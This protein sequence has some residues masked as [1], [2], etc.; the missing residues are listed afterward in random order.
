ML[1][2]TRHPVAQ[3]S[4]RVQ[5]DQTLTDWLVMVGAGRLRSDLIGDS[6]LDAISDPVG[7]PASLGR[8]VAREIKAMVEVLIELVSL[9]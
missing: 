5:L 2:T 9:G 6:V 8:S 4:S 7:E 3:L 1:D